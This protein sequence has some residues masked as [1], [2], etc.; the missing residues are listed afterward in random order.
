MQGTLAQLLARE[1]WAFLGRDRQSWAGHLS[2]VRTFLGEGL[3]RADRGRPVLVL[4]AGSGLEVPWEIAPAGS[5]GW[6]ADPLSRVRT[7]LR[8][9][10]WPRWR[11]GDLTGSMT[12][13]QALAARCAREPWGVRRARSRRDARERF[14]G[15]LPS[16]TPRP[17][18][19]ES[20]I[21]EFRPGTILSA[22]LMGQFGYVAQRMLEVHLGAWWEEAF[23][24]EDL[25]AALQAWL[26]RLLRAQIEALAASGAELWLVY[27]RGVVH[28]G[29]DLALGPWRD[30][31]PAQILGLGHAELEDPLAGIDVPGELLAH[32]RRSDRQERWLW[33]LA[34]GQTHVVEAVASLPG[35]E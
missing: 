28:G 30:P 16:L 34:P 35:G 17:S 7:C 29:H 18:A 21:A 6:D 2:R 25:D 9:R 32:G 5:V 15:L 12:D 1:Q 13:L 31:W 20:W 33:P 3:A 22:N 10:R 27:D 26:A 14:T 4:G 19:L 8:H 23:P 24:P 11:F